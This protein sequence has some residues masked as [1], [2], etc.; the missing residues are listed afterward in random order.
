MI[1]KQVL[2]M[3]ILVYLH[4]WLDF[5]YYERIYNNIKDGKRFLFVCFFLSFMTCYFLEP[6][7]TIKG[8]ELGVAF[9]AEIQVL[10][11]FFSVYLH[12]VFD[13]FRKEIHVI[14][15]AGEREMEGIIPHSNSINT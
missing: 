1:F 12:S 14:L 9:K 4:L 10:A 5:V 11:A 13:D 15:T 2:N 3:I 6:L 7:L 8:W